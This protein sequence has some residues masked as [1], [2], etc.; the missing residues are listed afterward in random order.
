MR[1]VSP[2]EGDSKA[3]RI[4]QT[5]HQ[6]CDTRLEGVLG[7]E[8]GIPFGENG[9]SLRVCGVGPIVTFTTSGNTVDVAVSFKF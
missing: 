9:Q 3:G 4:T 6:N 2:V 8:L 7:V 1:G 5:A